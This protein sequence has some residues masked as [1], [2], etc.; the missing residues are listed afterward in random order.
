MGKP[1]E[2]LGH[3]DALGSRKRIAVALPKREHLRARGARRDR[4]QCGAILH[5]AR[6]SGVRAVPFGEKCSS[7][8][9]A[10]TRLRVGSCTGAL[11]TMKL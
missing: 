8:V 7:R 2:R 10:S 4:Q 11:C 9:A 5:Q 1:R 6:V 3:A